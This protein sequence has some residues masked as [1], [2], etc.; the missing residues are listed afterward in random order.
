MSPPASSSPAE[1][2]D[3]RWYREPWPWLL[4]AG[5]LIVVAASLVTAW[6]AVR[7]D[8]GVVAQDYYKQGL[9]VNQRIKRM[10]PGPERRFG[11]TVRVAADGSVRVRIEELDVVP[12]RLRLK[13]SQPASATREAKVMLVPGSEGEY[14]GTMA[15]PA[16]GRWIVTLESDAW[17]LPTTTVADGL[18]EV[19]LGTAERR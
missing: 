8:D 18:A 1:R 5:P 12:Q 13:L 11:A 10:A 9:T 3:R 14:V 2:G 16:P 15:A 4:M 19:R 7:S 6:L 17:R